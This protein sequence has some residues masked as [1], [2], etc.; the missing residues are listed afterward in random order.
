MASEIAKSIQIICDEKGLNPEAVMEAIESA[1]AAAF[2]KDFGNRQGNY[3]V[4]FDVETGDMK[5]WDVKE[6]V[7][8]IPEAELEAA[9]EALTARRE[10]ARVEGRELSEEEMADLVRF[11]PKTQIMMKDAV[12]LVKKPTVGQV[13]ELPQEVPGA[14]GRMAAQTAKQVIMQKLR[15][16]ERGAVMSDFEKQVG[17]IVNGTVQRRDRSGNVII[18]LGRIT[19]L[20]PQNEQTPRDMYR[21]GTRMR[22]FVV[23]VGVG[24]RGPEIILSRKTPKMVEAIFRE[25]IPEIQ[26]G[27]V[28]IR[29]IARDAG[30]RSK[31]AVSTD[32]ESIDPIG[33]CIGQRG[34]RITTIITELGGE[35]VDIIQWNTNAVE[36]IKHALSPAKV[37][38]VELNEEAKEAQAFVVP[39]QFSLAIGRGGQN[40]RLAAEL[41]G[42]K[43]TV[44]EEGG[45]AVVSSEDAPETVEAVAKEVAPSEPQ[46][47]EKA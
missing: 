22:L 40:V 28:V 2:R 35:K 45:S 38:R 6:V 8:D 7:E 24:M 44:A 37:A 41:T 10:A 34:S 43:I 16:A 39:D 15:E 30:N 23:S 4:S 29:G 26:D 33:A 36:F 13:L 19:G 18:D 27:A 46:T 47:E 25:E 1:L 31:V 17:T 21:P 14:F 9:Q 11:N 3:K 12:E 5:V 20:L 42:W 32:D